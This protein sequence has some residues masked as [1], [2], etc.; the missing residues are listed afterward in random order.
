MVGTQKIAV[1]YKRI[2][3]IT[4]CLYNTLLVDWESLGICS[5]AY[6]RAEV[7]CIIEL[8]TDHAIYRTLYNV[9]A[10]STT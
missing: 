3:R 9:A 10:K 4:R 2:Y 5:S 1:R 8:L 7:I 6:L